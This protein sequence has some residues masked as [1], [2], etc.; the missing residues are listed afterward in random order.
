MEE[1]NDWNQNISFDS[2][3]Q[4]AMITQLYKDLKFGTKYLYF[5]VYKMII[6]HLF[7]QISGGFGG[8]PIQRAASRIHNWNGC[9]ISGDIYSTC[10]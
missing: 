5:S 3:K 6:Q 9:P 2:L 10:H 8:S 4:K 1:L 7:S